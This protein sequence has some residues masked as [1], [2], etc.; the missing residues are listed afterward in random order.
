VKL[1]IYSGDGESVPE[2]VKRYLSFIWF[3]WSRNVTYQ[4][5]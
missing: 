4:F 1:V 5:F 2:Y 3:L